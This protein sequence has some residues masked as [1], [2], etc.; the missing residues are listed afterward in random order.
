MNGCVMPK[1][2]KGRGEAEGIW[3]ANEDEVE[4]SREGVKDGV[5]Y[6]SDGG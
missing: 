5:V 3:E 2:E 1:K 4:E 6:L